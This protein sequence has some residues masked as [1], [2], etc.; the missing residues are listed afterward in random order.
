ME[1]DIAAY[2]ETFPK[3]MASLPVIKA[4]LFWINHY[5]RIAWKRAGHGGDEVHQAVR[6]I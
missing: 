6:V 3:M 1:A 2:F 4:W 5:E